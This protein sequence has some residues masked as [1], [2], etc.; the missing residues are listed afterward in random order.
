MRA[1]SNIDTRYLQ[2]DEYPLWN[3]F[4]DESSDGT[5]FHK[6]EWLE[7]ISAWQNLNFSIAA[8]FKG[9]RIVGGMAFTWK[10]KFG[11]IPIIQMPLKTPVFGPVIS[12]TDTKYRSKIERQVQA[13]VKELTGFLMSDYR[14]FHAQFPHS[15]SDMRPYVW[16][17]FTPALHYTY[18]ALFT[19]DFDPPS[20]V[21]SDINRRIKRA[22]ELTYTHLED[23]SEHYIGK[24]WDL[25]QKSFER[26]DFHQKSNHRISFI[27]LVQKLVEENVAQVYTIDHDGKSVASIIMI[28]DLVKKAAYYWMAGADKDYLPTGLNQL[29][30][31]HV[32]QK[33][34]DADFISFDLVGADTETIARYKSTLNFPLVPQYSIQKS[35][36]L[37][38]LALSL[39]SL[40]YK[41]RIV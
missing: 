28:Q 3:R 10:K 31:I 18:K 6:T 34:Q 2:A 22:S 17:G 27:K 1:A 24:A 14:F 40:L 5:I 11:R 36:K 25:E 23:N 8:C 30:L 33:C 37:M 41:G 39:K 12:F 19:K 9:G 32:V 38:Q 15:V 4:V 13:S 29:L 20:L 21:E 7:P 26:Q 16:A 35:G